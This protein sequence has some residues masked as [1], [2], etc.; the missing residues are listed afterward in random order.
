MHKVSIGF[1]SP[2]G[3]FGR[4]AFLFWFGIA[5]AAMALI[6]QVVQLKWDESVKPFVNV[7]GVIALSMGLLLIFW[8]SLKRLRDL[9]KSWAYVLLLLI[10]V[11]CI[12]LFLYL[13][14]KKGAEGQ[15]PSGNA[16]PPADARK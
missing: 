15:N 13:L 3:K 2:R 5:V 7:L 10:P 14:F 6:S 1:F 16:P 12:L 8:V 9:E 11:V 4:L